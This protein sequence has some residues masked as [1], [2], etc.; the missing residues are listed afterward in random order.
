MH[1]PLPSTLIHWALA[2]AL[3][4]P[5]CSDENEPEPAITREGRAL[6]SW[7]EVSP[8]LGFS[9][10]EALPDELYTS[11]LIWNERASD[12]RFTPS[13]TQ[14]RLRWCLAVPDPRSGLTRF[15]EVD[16]KCDPERVV[17]QTSACDDRLEATLILR[18]KSEDG[19]LSEN[20]PVT[21]TALSTRAASFSAPELALTSFQGTFVIS[22]TARPGL[23]LHFGAFG[24]IDEREAG[25]ALLAEWVPAGGAPASPGSDATMVY[26]VAN[27]ASTRTPGSPQNPPCSE[28]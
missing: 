19:A 14:T 27:W 11:D 26:T 17:T 28:F 12:V 24:G 2:G 25:G 7:D 1:R 10:A 20:L 21:F 23:T 15:E 9:I 5:A 22:N 6:A 4:L 13:G 18:L 3:L 8:L 16:V